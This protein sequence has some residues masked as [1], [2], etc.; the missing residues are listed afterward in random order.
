MDDNRTDRRIRGNRHTRNAVSIDRM[1]TAALPSWPDLAW[2]LPPSR[3]LSPCFSFFS[4]IPWFSLLYPRPTQSPARLDL[5][6]LFHFALGRRFDI[7]TLQL[8]KNDDNEWGP[9]TE[10]LDI[11]E[12]GFGPKV[13]VGAPKTKICDLVEL[14]GELL[15]T[16]VCIR[17]ERTRAATQSPFSRSLGPHFVVQPYSTQMR[18]GKHIFPLGWEYNELRILKKYATI[19]LFAFGRCKWKLL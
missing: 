18:F 15:F 6:R 1:E 7:R 3:P 2:T 12:K 17:G 9:Y 13:R 8:L 16:W 10:L 11:F 4:F 19:L 5:F 14:R